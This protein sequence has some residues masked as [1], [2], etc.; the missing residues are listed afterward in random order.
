MAK[1]DITENV[2]SAENLFYIQTSL[3][4]IFNNA[5]CSISHK[6]VSDRVR[7]SVTCPEYYADIIRAE[8]CDKIAEIIA[9]KYKHD[10]FSTRIK[11][12][13]LSEEEKE[14]LYV[15]LI[16]ADLI[17]DKKYCLQ[18]LKGHRD[19]AIDGMFNFRLKALKKKWEDVAEYMPPCFFGEQL[20]D[21]I[22]YLL[23]QR[24]KRVYV[25]NGKVYDGHYRRL[26]RN[27]LIG[28]DKLQI[29]SEVIL[30]NCG[31]VEI[32]GP[33]PETDEKYL[34]EYYGDKII[35]STG[36]FN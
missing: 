24:K 4:E 17:D 36:Y 12:G 10:F 32:S 5:D 15:S 30:S 34:K 26:K 25:D 19:V 11:V 20:K 14:I 16:A 8:V 7:L 27:M 35:F 18:M 1:I 6:R 22:T 33:L 3:S 2:S 28:Y 29:V 21:F 9:I 13:G 31:E 23:E